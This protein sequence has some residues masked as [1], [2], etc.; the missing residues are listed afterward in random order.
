MKSYQGYLIDLDGTIY[1]GK[2]RIPTAEKFVQEL[3]KLDFPFLI[4]TNNATSSPQ[5]VAERLNLH[6]DIP[7]KANHV[8]TSVLALID[9]LKLYHLNQ[10]IHVVGEESFKQMIVD[11][12]FMLDQTRLAE[13]VVQG[14]DRF[15]TYQTLNEAALAIRRG[16]TFLTTNEDHSIPTEDGFAPGSG[17]ITAFLSFTTQ[18]NP[19]I[20][21]KP[22]HHIFDGAIQTLGFERDA[23][24][25]IG[26]NYSTDILGGIQAG[27]DT[28]HV[29]T[30]VTSKE[31]LRQ[32]SIQPTYTIKDLSYWSLPK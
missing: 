29:Q 6:Y 27:V 20:V 3:V 8:Y 26:D 11:A 10:S 19:T 4:L 1:A 16:A 13:V 18:V 21:G 9:Y 30:G 25:M 22:H 12:G 14:L 24:L 23:I 28:L 17:A 31:A 5:Q 2:T 7:V 15:S 32:Y